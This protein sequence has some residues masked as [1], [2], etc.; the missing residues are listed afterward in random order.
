VPEWL[1]DNALSDIDKSARL[2]IEQ[3][4]AKGDFESATEL[5]KAYRIQRKYSNSLDELNNESNYENDK[6]MQYFNSIL[7]DA[8]DKL[9]S[10]D[11]SMHTLM[12]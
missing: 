5:V 10:N 1:N 9:V 2:K 7:R 11:Q 6:S 4:K 3:A 8:H 12:G